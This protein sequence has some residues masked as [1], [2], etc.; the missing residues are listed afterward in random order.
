MIIKTPPPEIFRLLQE[1]PLAH[2]PP[3]VRVKRLLKRPL[4]HFHSYR[5][6]RI[7]AVD[8]LD[9]IKLN[10][11]VSE[12]VMDLPDIDYAPVCNALQNVRQI[13]DSGNG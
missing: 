2:V 9:D 5:D 6:I 10:R 11:M 4:E 8:S 12:Y 1:I 3:R 13:L 7:A